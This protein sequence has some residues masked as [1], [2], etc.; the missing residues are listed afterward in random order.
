M[1][2]TWRFG[3]FS[4]LNL[5]KH[6]NPPCRHLPIA[7]QYDVPSIN[8]QYALNNYII[9]RPLE[10]SA[11]WFVQDQAES[12]GVDYRHVGGFDVAGMLKGKR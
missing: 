2:I 3:R 4:K 6:P 9:K 12:T 5:K 10:G 7:A 1:S 8:L 11:H